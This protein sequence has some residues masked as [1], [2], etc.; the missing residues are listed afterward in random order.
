[1]RRSSDADQRDI[2]EGFANCTE[3]EA[4][5]IPNQYFSS[6]ALVA[7]DRWVAFGVAPSSP[8]LP[9]VTG[10]DTPEVRLD[11]H[12]NAKGE[13]RH[14]WVDMPLARY[15]WQGRCAGGAGSREV[16]ESARLRQ[17]H[18]S[19]S[20]YLLRFEAAVRVA[21]AQR[22]LLPEHAEEAIEQAKDVR[23]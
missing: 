5:N 14:P 23:W 13:L 3:T 15:S 10:V 4:N 17:L 9:D 2:G 16:F 21:E 22:V 8:P 6:A 12:G 20:V 11:Q 18:G 1:M 7:L 19:P